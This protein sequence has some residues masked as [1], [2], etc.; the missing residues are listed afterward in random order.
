MLRKMTRAGSEQEVMN[1]AV[2]ASFAFIRVTKLNVDQAAEI[3][4]FDPH[5]PLARQI[6]RVHVGAG[7]AP[8]AAAWICASMLI[9]HRRVAGGV[10]VSLV[11]L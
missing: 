1:V 2:W 7:V 10:K 5:T 6:C 9:V 8:S 3:A 11:L 4:F